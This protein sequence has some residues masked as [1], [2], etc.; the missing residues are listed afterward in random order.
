MVH[1]WDVWAVATTQEEVTLGGAFTSAFDIRPSIAVAIDV[2]FATG[3]GADGW[4]T[5]PLN[6]GVPLGFGPN[7]HSYLYQ[8]FKNVAEKLDIPVRKDVMPRMSGTDAYA[9]QIAGEGIPSMI[10]SIPLRY[11]HTPVE[12]VTLKDIHR[13]GLLLAEYIARLTPDFVNQIRWD[14]E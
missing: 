2:T 4:R 11:M 13:T 3:P 12:M 6:K 7:V 5:H 10:L 8:S 9:M 1:A 14:E